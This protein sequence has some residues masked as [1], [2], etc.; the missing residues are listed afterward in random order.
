MICHAVNSN[1]EATAAIAASSHRW[2]IGSPNNGLGSPT[3]QACRRSYP[4]A[5]VA[6][7]IQ[8][9]HSGAKTSVIAITCCALAADR[10]EGPRLSRE[11]ARPHGSDAI[12]HKRD[13]SAAGKRRICSQLT[14]FPTHQPVEVNPDVPSRA[15][16][17]F[18]TE[19]LGVAARSRRNGSPH[20]VEALRHRADYEPSDVWAIAPTACINPLR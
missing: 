16:R 11:T 9:C 20:A 17:R 4:Q 15:A 18:P 7:L 13:N 12:L 10:T 6:I 1:Y 8:R 3:P 5:A 2:L 19:V 14:V